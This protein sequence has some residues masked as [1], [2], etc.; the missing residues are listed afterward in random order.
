M[1]SAP[2]WLASRTFSAHSTAP[3]Q[4]NPQREGAGG[5]AARFAHGREPG[6][7]RQAGILGADDDIPFIGLDCALP[8]IAAR[9]AGQVDMQVDHSG[10]HGLVFQIDRDHLCRGCSEAVGNADDL[11]VGDRYRGWPTRLAFGIDD[12]RARVDDSGIGQRRRGAHRPRQRD[13]CG[14][15]HSLSPWLPKGMPASGRRIKQKRR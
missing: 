11:P 3:V 9:I 6:K 15:L 12:K 2:F 10:Y 7:R 14:N 8:E 4:V 13:E 1:I 5:A